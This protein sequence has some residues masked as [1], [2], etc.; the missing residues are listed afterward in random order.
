MVILRV[1]DRS[2]YLVL[3]PV[4]KKS[5]YVLEKHEET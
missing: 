2:K 5:K 1:Y 4:D 3:I